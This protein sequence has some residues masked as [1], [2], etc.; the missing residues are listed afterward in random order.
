MLTRTTQKPVK[1]TYLLKRKKCIPEFSFYESYSV[2][3]QEDSSKEQ[4]RTTETSQRELR[5]LNAN[6]S[7]ILHSPVCGSK[8]A[9]LQDFRVKQGWSEMLEPNTE[10]TPQRKKQTQF[11]H[12]PLKSTKGLKWNPLPPEQ[13]HDISAP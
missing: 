7:E 4:R 9:I 1:T 12:N 10:E 5:H 13:A 3:A 11:P 6:Q 2:V 8:W